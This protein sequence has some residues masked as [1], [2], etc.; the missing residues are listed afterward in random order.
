VKNKNYVLKQNTNENKK[1]LS[2]FIFEDHYSVKIESK[3]KNAFSDYK[4]SEKW[5]SVSSA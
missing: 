3:R 5:P 2:N 1:T 4:G